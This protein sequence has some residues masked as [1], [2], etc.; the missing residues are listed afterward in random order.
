MR[1]PPRSPAGR[2]WPHAR[3]AAPVSGHAIAA[4]IP[5][6]VGDAAHRRARND[7]ERVKRQ[8]R[9]LDRA[10]GGGEW[11]GTPGGKAAKDW[12]SV[13]RDWHGSQAQAEHAALRERERL[14]QQ[15]ARVAE[16]GLPG[17]K[18]AKRC[19]DSR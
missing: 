18:E 6:D 12:R 15:A 19:G 5:T 8:W 7:A 2:P 13:V 3:P 14:R 11:R 16:G 4:V 10:E 17:P 9:D 1:L